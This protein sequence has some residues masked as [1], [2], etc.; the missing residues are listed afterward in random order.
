MGV[1]QAELL[2]AMR[3]VAVS[4]MSSVTALGTCL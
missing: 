2:T 3:H 1:E 4:S